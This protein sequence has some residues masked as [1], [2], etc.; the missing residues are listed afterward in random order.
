[1]TMIEEFLIGCQLIYGIDPSISTY[2]EHDV[3]MLP[4]KKKK[5]E[6]P[7]EIQTKL[8]E[9]GFQWTDDSWQYLT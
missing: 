4:G 9:F 7:I 8:E 1:M 3:I 2:A 6:F 5:K